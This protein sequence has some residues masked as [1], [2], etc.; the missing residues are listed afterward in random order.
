MPQV[1]EIE[2]AQFMAWQS[3]L[4]N[5]PQMMLSKTLLKRTAEMF[6]IY[7]NTLIDELHNLA[8]KMMGGQVQAPG[9]QG[10]MPGIT[11]LMTQAASSTGGAAAGINNIRGGK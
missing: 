9:Q 11:D 6:H 5:A 2:R 4:A 3:M 1:P 10:S 7:D 8:K